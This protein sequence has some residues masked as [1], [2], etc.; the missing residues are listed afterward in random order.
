VAYFAPYIDE[1]GYHMPTYTDIRDYYIA[2][3]RTIF[4]ADIYLEIDSQDY[5]WI[6]V[7]ANAVYDAFLAEQAA[8]N[9]RS[10]ATAIGVPLDTLIKLNGIKRLKAV[11]STCYVTITG[12]TGTTITGGIIADASDNPWSLNSPIIIG[13]SGTVTAY[14]TCQVPGPITADPGELSKIVTPTFGWTSV[15]NTDPATVG[16]DQESDAQLRSRQTI[17]T[18]QPS[19]TV[20]EGI[21]GA[22]AAVS[23][24]GRFVVYEN[25]TNV[26]DENGLP[27]HSI[28]AVV[29][30]GADADIGEAIARKKGPGCYT[31][32]D[33]SVSVTDQQGVASTIRFYRPA[34]VP[35]VVV[36]NVKQLPGYTTDTTDLIKSAVADFISSLS[37]GDDL[38]IS[39]LWGAAVM[40]N[41]VP[42]KPY[43]SVLGITAAR[44]GNSQGTADIVIDFNEVTL[45]DVANIT[46]NVT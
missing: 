40:A 41:P 36:V 28:T 45:G 7:V 16:A 8:Y 31:N 35:I 25:E 13:S 39:S 33:V 18:A 32:G 15:T 5:Q 19:R 9:S 2:Q 37:I 17:S 26:D 44:H 12:T 14:A 30:G 29:E 27:G 11:A 1:S 10:P 21:K 43:F 24:V 34:E 4:G 6:S 23:G 20:M 22:I 42:T 38:L 46:V 3:A